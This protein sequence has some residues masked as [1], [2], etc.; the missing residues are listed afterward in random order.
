MGYFFGGDK[1]IERYSFLNEDFTPD[2][3]L[4]SFSRIEIINFSFSQIKDF[5][6]FGYGAGGFETVFKLK[7]IGKLISLNI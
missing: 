5:L 4:T 1:L 6:F 3:N 7:F 2:N